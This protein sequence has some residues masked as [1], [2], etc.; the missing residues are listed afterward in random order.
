MLCL[1]L[2]I[3]LLVYA[4][5]Y[6]LLDVFDYSNKL[7][8]SF[9]HVN[10]LILIISDTQFDGGGGEMLVATALRNCIIFSFLFQSKVLASSKK[11]YLPNIS[12][13]LLSIDRWPSR[14]A[15]G[16]RWMERDGDGGERLHCGPPWSQCLHQQ[17]PGINYLNM[18]FSQ[19]LDLIGC[20]IRT[21]N[22]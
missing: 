1:A 15:G 16:R 20:D 6:L 22:A 19:V 9:I 13:P 2:V 17:P 7:F 8:H 10:T 3:W 14:I 18:N 21:L 5:S 4:V 12:V 11:T